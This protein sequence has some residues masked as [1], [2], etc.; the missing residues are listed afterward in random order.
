MYLKYNVHH[1]KFDIEMH[2][3]K[4]DEKEKREEAFKRQKILNYTI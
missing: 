2:L 1:C 4:E 3:Y